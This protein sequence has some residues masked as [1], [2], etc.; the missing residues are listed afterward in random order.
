METSPNEQFSSSQESFETCYSGL[1]VFTGSSDLDSSLAKQFWM[2][3]SLYPPN[4]SQLALTRGS[5]QRLPVAGT[6][7]CNEVEKAY[8]QQ[9]FVDEEKSA[10]IVKIQE[11]EEKEKYLQ[12]AKRR[13]EILQLL[14][15]Q[16]EERILESGTRVR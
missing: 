4:E 16:R 2:A 9:F 14:R 8:Y 6:S 12:K 7:K 10:E 5:S 13:D 11:D 3:A 1:L 15:K